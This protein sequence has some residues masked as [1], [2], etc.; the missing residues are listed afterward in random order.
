MFERTCYQSIYPLLFYTIFTID[1][2]VYYVY[3]DTL[4]V[5]LIY[6]KGGTDYKECIYIQL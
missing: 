2:S 3:H 4:V 1:G 6:D 5:P